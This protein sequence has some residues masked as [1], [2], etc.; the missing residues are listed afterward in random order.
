MDSNLGMLIT[1]LFFALPIALNSLAILL[2][3]SY[4]SPIETDA[5]PFPSTYQPMEMLIAQQKQQQAEAIE[6]AVAA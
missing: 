3:A 5:Q 1:A 6:H 2:M 4:R